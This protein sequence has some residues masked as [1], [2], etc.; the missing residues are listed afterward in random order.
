MIIV[1]V[2]DEDGDKIRCR[3]AVTSSECAG[4][5]KKLYGSVLDEVWIYKL[6]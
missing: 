6:E 4:V 2:E 3:W 1:L 5:C